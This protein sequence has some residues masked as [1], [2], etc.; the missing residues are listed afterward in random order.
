MMLLRVEERISLLSIRQVIPTACWRKSRFPVL[1]PISASFITTVDIACSLT[2]GFWINFA[3]STRI[4]ES[5]ESRNPRF[6][7][8]VIKSTISA[9][10]PVCRVRSLF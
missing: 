4:K 6:V 1:T 5:Q 9:S 8:A 7:R 3:R 10:Y 2:D